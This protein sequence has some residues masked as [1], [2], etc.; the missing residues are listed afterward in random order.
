MCSRIFFW[1]RAGR[2]STSCG[3]KTRRKSGSAVSPCGPRI[4]GRSSLG[5]VSTASSLEEEIGVV[6]EVALSG[7]REFLDALESAEESSGAWECGSGFGT[8]AQKDVG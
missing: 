8:Q 6:E 4:R 7:L 1:S 3:P 5:A 2:A